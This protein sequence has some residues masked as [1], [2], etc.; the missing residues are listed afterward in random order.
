MRNTFLTIGI[1]AAII[2]M[3]ACTKQPLNHL[4]DDESR[5]YISNHDDSVSFNAF[6]TFSIADSV[7]VISNNRLRGKALTDVDSAYINAV[8]QQMIQKGYTLVANNQSPDLGVDVSRIYNTYTGVVDYSGY[9]GDYYGYW[10]PYY[11][12]FPGYGYYFPSYGVYQVS[13]GALEVDILDLKDASADKQIKDIW[14][15]LIRGTG[16]FD[17]ANAQSGVQ[18]LFDQSSYLKTGQ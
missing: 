1:A 3:S 18:S 6:K 15:G 7:A 2:S 11:W 14:S 9:G 17:V 13:E 16:V 5:L 8:K 4:T 12:G 10:D